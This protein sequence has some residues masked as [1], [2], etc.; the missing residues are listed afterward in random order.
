M[1]ETAAGCTCT[2][3]NRRLMAHLLRVDEG[4]VHEEGCR[5]RAHESGRV[6]A[7]AEAIAAVEASRK[8]GWPGAESR[9][10]LSRSAVLDAL[11]SLQESQ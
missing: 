5:A 1:S 2:E 3:L 7:L 10:Y 6:A 9:P 11:R 4:D 8:Y